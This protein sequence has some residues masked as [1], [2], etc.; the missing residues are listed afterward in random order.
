MRSKT[1]CR[2]SSRGGGT[3]TECSN[4][5]SWI[6]CSWDNPMKPSP[7]FRASDSW[8][9]PLICVDST[10]KWD[11]GRRELNPG[12]KG[13]RLIL[14]LRAVQEYDTT[15]SSAS[16]TIYATPSELGKAVLNERESVTTGPTNFL[17]KSWGQPYWA[18][19]DQ[20]RT[21]FSSYNWKSCKTK[22]LV[23]ILDSIALLQQ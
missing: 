9:L 18:L 20:Q 21:S 22:P 13:C 7:S 5:G 14:S 15:C 12:G 4:L 3:W 8:F 6:K 10:L 2:G 17:N 1:L 16:P 19:L 11:D 23:G